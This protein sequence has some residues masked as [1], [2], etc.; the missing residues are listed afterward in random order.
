MS[1]EDV[2]KRLRQRAE[3]CPPGEGTDCAMVAITA[4]DGLVSSL[5]DDDDMMDLAA[6]LVATIMSSASTAKI[7]PQD[8]WER[9]RSALETAAASADDFSG[10]VSLMC[11]KLQI[12]SLSNMSALAVV[13]IRDKAVPFEAFRDVCE[14]KALYV[15]ATVQARRLRAAADEDTRQGVLV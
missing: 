12:D 3:A 9:A 14:R 1:Y 11:K 15:V 13:D 2:V 10:V 8:W 4:L 5:F 7:R 6:D